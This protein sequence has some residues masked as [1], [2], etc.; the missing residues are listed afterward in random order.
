MNLRDLEYF[1]AVAQEGHFG[2]AAHRC[3]VSQPTLSG[4]LR[5]LE[6][7]L[8]GPLLERNT[9]AVL[10]TG[11]GAEIFDEAQKVLAGVRRISELAAANAD[12]LCG[13]LRMGV[14][15]TMGPWWL[16]QAVP[17]LQ[18]K[19]SNLQF[20]FHELRTPELLERLRNGELD[21]AFFAEPDGAELA[22]GSIAF[23]PFYLLVSDKHLLAKRKSIRREELGSLELLLLEEGHCL[24]DE[25]LDLCRRYGAKET[26]VYRATGIETLRQT[27]RLGAGV[28]LMPALSVVDDPGSGLKAI[29]FAEPVPGRRIALRWRSTH[30]RAQAMQMIAQE[31]RLWAKKQKALI[32]IE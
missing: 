19:F 22:G 4:Q 29:P 18:K 13:P 16:P 11:L 10:L 8:G 9:R 7:E 30:P 12:P 26:G 31:M 25:V 20:W 15:P 17:Q 21:C 27:V 6:Q 1:V 14:F 28:T 3:F 32:V 23:E 24:R 2:K 5:K